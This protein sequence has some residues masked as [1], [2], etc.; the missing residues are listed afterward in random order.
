HPAV[1]A[2][3]V[4]PRTMDQLVELLG[5]DVAV[6]DDQVLDAI[7]ALVAPGTT[8]NPRDAGWVPPALEDANLRRRQR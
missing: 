2:A 5:A 1:S 4:G 7:D 6:L 8:L 3:I